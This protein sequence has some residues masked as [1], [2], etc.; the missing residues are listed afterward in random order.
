M[1]AQ[2]DRPEGR[3]REASNVGL[4]GYYAGPGVYV[5]DRNALTDP[6][7]ARL[8]PKPGWRV[9]HYERAVP[10]EYEAS[11]R[12]DRNLIADPDLR[13]LYDDI[14]RLTRADIWSRERWGV[15]LRSLK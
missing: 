12:A 6:F 3:F 9:G 13:L 4:F 10:A 8:P 11:R 15:I 2:A 14:E 5:I 1:R 7:L